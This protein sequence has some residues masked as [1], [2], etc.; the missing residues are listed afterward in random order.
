MY[1]KLIQPKMQ[2]R[3][4]DS[5]IKTHMS[6]PLG[7]YTIANMLRDRHTVSVENEN[8]GKIQLYDHPDAVGISITV[9]T[10][11][12]AIKIARFYR[13]R[14]I[15]VIAGGIFVTTASEFI[16]KGCFDAL[17]IGA[18]ELTWNKIIE[19]LQ[20]GCL[21]AVYRCPAGMAGVDI[22]SPAYDMI[23]QADY[24]YCNI[25]HTSRGCPYRC[26]F[27]YNSAAQRQYL[28]RPINDV[29]QDIKAIGSK[30]I[31]FIDDNFTGNI[32]WTWEFLQKLKPL[33]IKWNAASSID[34]VKHE[35]LLDEMK[36]CGCQSLFI[37]FES[38]NGG[39]VEGV[40]KVQN[41]ADE[42]EEAV[43]LIHNKGIMIN[44]SFV[45]GLDSDTPRV[46]HD[47][48]D[49]VVRN[50]IETVTSHIL[51]PYPG[52]KLYDDMHKAG[53]ITS[54]D[55]SRYNTA[56]VVFKPLG[57][58]ERELYDGYLWIYKNIY[59]FQNI[60]KRIPR[61]KAQIAPY[62]LFNLFYRKFG[63]F[64]DR[65]CKLITYN[66]IGWMAEKIVRY[67]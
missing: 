10:L 49:W 12:R 57:M 36:A 28:N 55:L 8:I 45:F 25:V 62:L 11:P 37:G 59:S 4:M 21:K 3:P 66:K 44:A 61:D 19:D 23:K 33:H 34:I 41:H 7:L 35:D 51:T 29:L 24:L 17:C 14:G 6:P 50:R 15:P 48:L 47:T 53:R 60:I 32:R 22:V 1:I 5:D 20:N 2:K 42:Y 27:C 54:N 39:S 26:D 43:K 31:M 38:I 65:L 46:F 64:T 67:L 63:N 52:T 56:N 13:K 18:A 16:P 30:H 58:T 9:D 40:H